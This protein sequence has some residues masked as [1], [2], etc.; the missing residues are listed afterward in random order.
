MVGQAE[1]ERR[2][3]EL[4]VSGDQAAL[5]LLLADHYDRL[6]GAIA[7]EIGHK[8]DRLYSADDCA[9]DTYAYVFDRISDFE[10]RGPDSFLDWLK[11]IARNMAIDAARVEA[12]EKRG[13]KANR[14]HISDCQATRFANSVDAFRQDAHSPSRAMARRELPNAIRVALARLNDNERRVVLARYFDNLDWPR[15][16]ERMGNSVSGVR[17]ICHR[18]LDKLEETLGSMSRYVT[19]C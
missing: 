9:Q 4:V 11:Q 14:I 1:R 7:F 15:V 13:G 18:A 19:R 2:L 6:K 17:S 10:Y 3:L 8:L 16:A 5:N 12:A